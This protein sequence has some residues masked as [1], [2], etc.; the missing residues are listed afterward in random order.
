MHSW[1]ISHFGLWPGSHPITFKLAAACKTHHISHR[2]LQPLWGPYAPT[3][4]LI[5]QLLVKK[6][7][8]L[9]HPSP[10]TTVIHTTL[11]PPTPHCM[12]TVHHTPNMQLGNWFHTCLCPSWNPPTRMS[13]MSECVMPHSGK[14][15][16]ISPLLQGNIFERCFFLK[17]KKWQDKIVILLI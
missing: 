8:G 9:G 17:C 3:T 15:K 5:N 7:K 11:T 6:K 13:N 1:W 16:C 4:T 14:E 10:L 12:L 2:A